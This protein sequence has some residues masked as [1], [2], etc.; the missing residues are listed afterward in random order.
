MGNLL[1]A[2]GLAII[3]KASWKLVSSLPLM[4]SSKLG[5]IMECMSL[6]SSIKLRIDNSSFLLVH[7]LLLLI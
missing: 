3:E 1:M 4:A 6:D 5:L 2:L 7:I